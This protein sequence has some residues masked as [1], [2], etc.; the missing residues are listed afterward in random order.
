MKGFLRQHSSATRLHKKDDSTTMSI[1]I[2]LRR[3][4]T[5]L[6]HD[7]PSHHFLH[8]LMHLHAA[9]ILDQTARAPRT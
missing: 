6:V 5:V 8:C 7:T 9:L 4:R 1:V 3:D 2:K